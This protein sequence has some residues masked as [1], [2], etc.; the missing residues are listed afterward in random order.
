[1][2]RSTRPFYSLHQQI[3]LHVVALLV[4]LLEA[5]KI[6]DEAEAVKMA[7]VEAATTTTTDHPVKSAR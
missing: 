7:V 6:L 4:V 5:V 3:K 2:R 1:M